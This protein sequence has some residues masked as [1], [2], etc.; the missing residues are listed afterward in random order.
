MSD[1]FYSVNICWTI[2]RKTFNSLFVRTNLPKV[3]EKLEIWALFIITLNEREIFCIYHSDGLECD[4]P[5]RRINCLI[6]FITFAIIKI[7]TN[8]GVD[9]CANKL[10]LWIG[11]RNYET[12]SIGKKYVSLFSQNKNPFKQTFQRIHQFLF[13]S[14]LSWLASRE[15]HVT[16]IPRNSVGFQNWFHFYLASKNYYLYQLWK[17][18]RNIIQCTKKRGITAFKLYA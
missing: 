10:S 18:W 16:E 4:N 17:A 2:S 3:K 9:F 5:F 15:G 12:N 7:L 11:K 6:L 14:T 1:G 13:L 8:C